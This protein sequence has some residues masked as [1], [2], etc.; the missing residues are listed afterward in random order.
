MKT[1]MKTMLVMILAWC[2]FGESAEA[3]A[4]SATLAW[5]NADTTDQVRV[6]KAS[7]SSGT[8]NTLTTLPAGTLTYT[9]TTNV[10]GSTPCY[11]VENVNSSGAGPSSNVVCKAFPPMPTVAPVMHPIP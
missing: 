5:D 8:F 1:I 3:Q 11:R 10:A 2:L 6:D 7:S 9:D 4:L